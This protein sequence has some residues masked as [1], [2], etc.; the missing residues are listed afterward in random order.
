MIP[1]H[2]LWLGPWGPVRRFDTELLGVLRVQPLPT[3]ELRGVTT[4]D[5]AD[6]SSAEQVI[7]NIERNVPPGSTHRDE[8]AIDLGPQRQARTAAGGIEFPTHIAVL[9]RLG[10]FD[11][12]HFGFQR[13]G[14][15]H[16]GKFH[17]SNGAQAPIDH[18]GSPLAQLR[19]VGECLPDFCRRVAQ[20]S[21]ENERPLL[22]SVFSTCARLA[23]PG[24]YC[25]GSVIFFFLLR[26]LATMLNGP[27]SVPTG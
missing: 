23:G 15:S 22:L 19:R 27:T 24:V 26:F 17:R 8:A 18:K 9:K 25:S 7:Q 2:L 3:G 11:S 1:S 12:R 13:R 21:D 10:S 4:S 6:G 16:P 20:F 5:A 14:V